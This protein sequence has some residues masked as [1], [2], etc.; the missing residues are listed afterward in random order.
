[1]SAQASQD[2]SGAYPPSPVAGR[3]R[4]QLIESGA[5]AAGAQAL[6]L[7]DV[8][9]LKDDPSPASRAALAAKFG[10]QYDHLVEGDTRPL[11]EAVLELLVRDLE[12][13][14]RQALAEA[15]AASASLPHGVATRLA[16]DELDVAR[17][18]LERSPVLSDEDLAEIV[19]THAMQYAL[20]VAGREHLSEWLS[21]VLADTNEPEV[22]ATLTGNPGAKL[23]VATLRRIADDYRGDRAIQDRLIRRPALPYELVD[24]LVSAIGERLEWEL[25]QQRRISKAEARQLMA[26]ARDRA[27]LSIVAREHGEKSIERELR[28]RFT[29]GELGPE[30]IVAFLRDGEIARVEAGLA[31]LADVDVPRTRQLLYGMDKRGLAALCARAGFGAPH[32]LALRMALDLAEQ[33]MQGAEPDITYS[34][35][36][37]TFVQQQFDQIRS[38]R[39]QIA[40]W[41]A[42]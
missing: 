13:N 6:S 16:R 33:G 10:R 17:P 9:A 2:L 19:R 22:V 4:A 7:A 12:K 18:L 3:R 27:T 15:V 41:F 30:D 29:T 42:N 38:D 5:R 24:Q 39:G 23:S 8:H 34:A 25:I 31:L 35:E 26:A 14:V 40:P 37:I 1:M 11:A 28:H 20:A 36:T 32:Y 21:D